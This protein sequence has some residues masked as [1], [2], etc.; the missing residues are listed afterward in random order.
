MSESC[1]LKKNDRASRHTSP[2]NQNGQ[3]DPSKNQQTQDHA[4][5]DPLQC[6]NENCTTATQMVT[7]HAKLTLW[8]RIKA[9]FSGGGASVSSTTALL[10]PGANPL[11]QAMKYKTR[12][13][14]PNEGPPPPKELP[15]PTDQPPNYVPA[16]DSPAPIGTVPASS[17]E[18][19]PLY[20][21]KPKNF[22]YQLLQLIG[23]QIRGAGDFIFIY[24]MDPAC[25]NSNG[26]A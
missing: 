15:W 9:W 7:V 10:P 19:N 16:S 14:G 22:I 1:S 17:P 18:P 24:R 23:D 4:Q 8:Q 25:M 26:C 3:Q 6:T 11:Q 2:R 21:P 12:P 13:V 5:T 20:T